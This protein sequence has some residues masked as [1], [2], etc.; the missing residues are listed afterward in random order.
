MAT[1]SRT[2]FKKRQKEMARKEKQRLK[3]ERRAQRKLAAAAHPEG[4]PEGDIAPLETE[5]DTD[6]RGI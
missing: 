6:L 4:A 3:A 1:R 2:T 5:P